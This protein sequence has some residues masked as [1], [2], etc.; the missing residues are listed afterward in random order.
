M[1]PEPPPGSSSP[2]PDWPTLAPE[3]LYGVAGQI[4][5][6]IAPHS[7]ADPVAILVHTL[8]AVGNLL[9]AGPHARVEQDHHA[10]RLYA[11]LVGR[12]SKGRKGTAW[13]TPRALLR[14]VDPE[15]TPPPGC[16]PV[17]G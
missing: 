8:V 17:R 13:S 11:V 3:A 12:S 1:T 10:A 7:E 15:W 14:A 2:E 9:G 4:V 6:A 16:Q 5:E